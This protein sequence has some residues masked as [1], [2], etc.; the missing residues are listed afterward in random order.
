MQ[1]LTNMPS[2]HH[3][4]Q[5]SGYAQDSWMNING[6]SQPP[7]QHNISPMNEYQGFDYGHSP[8]LPIGS[9]YSMPRPPPYNAPAHHPLP[10]PLVMPQS[11]GVW[12]SMLTSSNQFPTPI[13]P[14]GPIH[15]PVSAATSHGSDITPTSAKSTSRRK[16]TDEERRQMCLEAENNPTMKQTQIGG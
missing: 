9:A 6:Y 12:P 5:G 11:N 8:S 1:V 15:T 2:S 14:A 16:L 10:P 4:S 13:L 3:Q 7:P